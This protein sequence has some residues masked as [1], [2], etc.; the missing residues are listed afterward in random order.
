MMGAGVAG[1]VLPL[2]PGVVGLAVEEALLLA[3][4]EGLGLTGAV[5]VPGAVVGC[6][7]TGGA[8]PALGQPANRAM[9]RVPAKKGRACV[10]RR[11]MGRLLT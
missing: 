6:S 4:A 10:P 5:D 9:L 3:D 11:F 2:L 8:V 1:A 7:P